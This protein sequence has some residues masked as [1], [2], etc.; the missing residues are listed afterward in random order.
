MFPGTP[1]EQAYQKDVLPGLTGQ[2]YVK[3]NLAGCH[4]VLIQEH[5]ASSQL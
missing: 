4:F 3:Y 2:K 1:L 5:L